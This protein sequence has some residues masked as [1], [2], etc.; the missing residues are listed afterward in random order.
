[1]G[2]ELYGLDYFLHLN[3]IFIMIGIGEILDFSTWSEI[4]K[5]LYHISVDEH[6]ENCK[7]LHSAPLDGNIKYKSYHMIHAQ[8]WQKYKWTSYHMVCK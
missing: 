5:F 2:D 8:V 7:N 3:V 4:K 1:M 6:V